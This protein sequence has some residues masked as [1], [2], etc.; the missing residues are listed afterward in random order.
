MRR[1]CSECGESLAGKAPQTKTCS[2]SCRAKR[3]RRLKRKGSHGGGFALPD[4]MKTMSEVVRQEAPDIA[5]TVIAEELRPVVREA[6]T[7]D[8]LRSIH[9]L[10]ALTPNAI[11]ALQQDLESDDAVIRSKATTLVL[12]YTLGHPALVRPDD[13]DPGKQLVVNLNLPRPELPAEVAGDETHEGEVL[14]DAVEVR[15]CDMCTTTLPVADF[16]ADSYRCMKCWDDQRA[17]VIA[18]YGTD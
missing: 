5:H 17:S 7:E 15:T 18:R 16:A 1:R 11:A 12:K 8:V 9:S 13:T 14:D 4:E 6:M 10:V 2:T 3:S